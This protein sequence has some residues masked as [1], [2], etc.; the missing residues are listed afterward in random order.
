MPSGVYDHKKAKL[1]SDAI[2]ALAKGYGAEVQQLKQYAAARRANRVYNI[3]QI[4]KAVEGMIAYTK[5]CMQ[6]SEPAT[7][8]GLI[9]ASGTNKDFFY[10]AKAGQ[11]D[12]I[13]LEYI[14]E[15]NITPDQVL[16]DADGLEYVETGQNSIIAISPCSD[17]IEKC[18]LYMEADLQRRSLTDKSMARTTGAIFNL[19]AVFNYNDKPEPEARTV[20]NTLILNT[21]ADQA[22]EAMKLLVNNAK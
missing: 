12:H 22:A 8:A 5:G 17:V 18:L 21:N 19:K 20:N 13:S 4:T 2:T 15:H 11:Y 3:E 14:Q 1:N 16:T 6:R 10:K 9:L 7:I